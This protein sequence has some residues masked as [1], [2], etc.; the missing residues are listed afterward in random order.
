[1]AASATDR[2][3]EVVLISERHRALYQQYF[4]TKEIEA[5]PSRWQATIEE[6]AIR[7]AVESIIDYGCGKAACVSRTSGLPITNYDPCIPEFSAIPD[8]ADLVVCLHVLEHVEAECIDNVLEHMQGLARK[9]VFIAVSTQQST[10]VLPDGTPWH[11][12][13]RDVDWWRAKL[14]GFEELPAMEGRQEYVA[15]RC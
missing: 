10:K 3:G 12:F 5:R 4:E 7:F 8:R 9:A 13:V 14:A 1:V 11:S 15:L 6:L 2:V